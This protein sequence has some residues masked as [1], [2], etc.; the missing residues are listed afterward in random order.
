M[1]ESPERRP[2]REAAQILAELER[3]VALRRARSTA[4]HLVS[5][6]R[7]SGRLLGTLLVTRGFLM[8]DE[9]A[10]ALAVQ[11]QS[12]ERLGEV[13][14]RLRLIEDNDLAELLAEQLR[15]DTIRLDRVSVDVAIARL[16]PK[17]EMRARAA[18]PFRRRD[19]HIDVALADPTD[20]VT[21]ALLVQALGGPIRLY[22]TT[23][24]DVEAALDRLPDRRT[25][26]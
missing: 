26:V 22:V 7:H 25:T 11:Q 14:K 21:V 5:G 10:H 20:E 17:N 18:F 23:R 1:S 9:L 12:G 4:E 16:L 19:A 6:P 3:I 24:A 2:D 8:P 15:L 13:L